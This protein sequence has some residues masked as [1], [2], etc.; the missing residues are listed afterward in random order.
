MGAGIAFVAARGGY[1]VQLVDPDAAGLERGRARV[2][3]DAERAG[4]AS[5]ASRITFLAA[6]PPQSDAVIA[7]EAVP[8]R[9]DLKRDVFVALEAALP[10]SALLATNTSSLS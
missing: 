1:N 4:D 5:I 2:K 6:I 9:F 8:E 10:S 3:K 7:I